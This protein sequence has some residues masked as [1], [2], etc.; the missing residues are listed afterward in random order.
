MNFQG[1][2][3]LDNFQ[4]LT[5]YIIIKMSLITFFWEKLIKWVLPEF[6]FIIHLLHQV[7]TWFKY[8][9]KLRLILQI[10]GVCAQF[11][12]SSANW[13]RITCVSLGWGMSLTYIKNKKNRGKGMP[14]G[15]NGWGWLGHLVGH[16]LRSFIFSGRKVYDPSN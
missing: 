5:P 12:M 2:Y 1:F 6:S 9:C 15:H 10:P 14:W 16:Y 11:A 3:W 13:E 8:F 4:W 7:R